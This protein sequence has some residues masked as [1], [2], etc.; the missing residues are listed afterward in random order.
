[1]RPLLPDD[2]DL[3]D[4]QLAARYA[5]PENLGAPFVRVNFVASADGAV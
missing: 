3:D 2:H 4:E 5:Y 1:M